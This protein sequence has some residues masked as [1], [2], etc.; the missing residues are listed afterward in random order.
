MKSSTNG[1]LKHSIP[2]GKKNTI[3]KIKRDFKKSMSINQ[4]GDSYMAVSG[5]SKKE[6]SPPVYNVTHP[7]YVTSSTELRLTVTLIPK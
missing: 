3:T 1:G 2:R 4:K 5:K 7:F 6:M